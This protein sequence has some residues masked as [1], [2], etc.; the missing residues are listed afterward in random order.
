[1]PLA[2]WVPY[3]PEFNA[4]AQVFPSQLH[5]RQP[6]AHIEV[7]QKDLSYTFLLGNYRQ[8]ISDCKPQTLEVLFQLQ[9][10]LWECRLNCDPVSLFE[11]IYGIMVSVMVPNMGQP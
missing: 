11:P 9:T 7:I 4:Q 3:N 1:M 6:P 2:A 10:Q 8:P 5:V